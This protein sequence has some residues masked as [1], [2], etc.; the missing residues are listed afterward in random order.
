MMR[1]RNVPLPRSALRCP[2]WPLDQ[3]AGAIGGSRGGAEGCDAADVASLFE[4]EA[5][6]VAPSSNDFKVWRREYFMSSWGLSWR[7]ARDYPRRPAPSGTLQTPP[8]RP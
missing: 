5:V 3:R 6:A 7:G 1:F 8:L 2:S 4:P